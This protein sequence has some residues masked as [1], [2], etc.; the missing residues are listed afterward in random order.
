MKDFINNGV[1][2]GPKGPQGNPGMEGEKGA[3]G[4]AGDK[5][6][7][8]RLT[9]IMGTHISGYFLIRVGRDLLLFVIKCSSLVQKGNTASQVGSVY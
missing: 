7:K 5:G 3:K 6:A 1:I 9:V 8:G 2:T 4:P